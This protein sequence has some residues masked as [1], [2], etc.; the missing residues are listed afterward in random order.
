M[1]IKIT[2][3]NEGRIEQEL[4]K[5]NGKGNPFAVSTYSEIESIARSVENRLSTLSDSARKGTSVHYHPGGLNRSGNYTARSTLISMERGA[6]G[7]FFV[8][9]SP[10][11]VNPKKARYLKITITPEQAAEIQRRAIEAFTISK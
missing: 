3:K 2:P 7:W 4:L 5:A 1:R 11:Q 6:S 9:A 8:G 10:V